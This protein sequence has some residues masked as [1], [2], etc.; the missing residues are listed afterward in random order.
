[1]VFWNIIAWSVLITR[2]P[3]VYYV[4]VNLGKLLWI[5]NMEENVYALLDFLLHT[6][7]FQKLAK[8]G[9]VHG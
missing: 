7:L 2:S 6:V 4:K 8:D 9:S 1:M 5:Q 3:S